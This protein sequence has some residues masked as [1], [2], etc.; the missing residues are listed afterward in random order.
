MP[1]DPLDKANCHRFAPQ[2]P[3]FDLVHHV[4]F[5]VF[6]FLILF[7]DSER[8]LHQL[9]AGLGEELGGHHSS[10]HLVFALKLFSQ[11][12][13]MTTYMQVFFKNFRG[14]IQLINPQILKM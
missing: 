5:E 11:V 3:D 9:P 7:K 14:W 2:L 1:G 13:S 10:S 6:G 4:L 12:C 8:S